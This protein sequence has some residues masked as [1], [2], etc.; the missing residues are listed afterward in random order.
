MF[1]N[2]AKKQEGD[3]DSLD[4]FDKEYDTTKILTNVNSN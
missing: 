2:K 4:A 1:S 3:I